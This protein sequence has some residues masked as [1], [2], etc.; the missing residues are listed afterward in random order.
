VPHRDPRRIAAITIGA[1]P[2][3]DLTEVLRSALPGDVA[4]VESGALDDLPDDEAPPPP[5]PG[6]LPLTTRRRDGRPVV[7]DESWL[8]PRMTAAVRQAEADGADLIVLLCA[9][10]F[11]TVTSGVPMI[12]PFEAAVARLRSLGARRIAVLVPVAG[13]VEPS[14]RRWADAGFEVEVAAGPPGA[15]GGAIGHAEPIDAVVL[16]FV[17]HAPAD[18]A[19][20]ARAV[21]PVPVIDLSAAMVDAVVATMRR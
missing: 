18:V 10:G 3:P 7:A 5:A 20:A 15:V 17:G 9:G 8:A 6:G 13:Q 12:R 21:H 14:R 19:A 16:D 11:A 2:R 4:V 1:A